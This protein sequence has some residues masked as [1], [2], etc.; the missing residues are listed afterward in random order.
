MTELE[1][2]EGPGNVGQCY[3]VIMDDFVGIY[4]KTGPYRCSWFNKP[5]KTWVRSEV[6]REKI[7]LANN[8][9]TG[10]PGPAQKGGLT[11]IECYFCRRSAVISGALDWTQQE[12]GRW[13]CAAGH[14]LPEQSAKPR[15]V[16][17]KT[18]PAVAQ[19]EEEDMTIA[20]AKALELY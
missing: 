13:L 5:K 17:V 14:K 7:E 9:E 19:Q 16:E 12:D 8:P 3:I 6:T 4:Q 20:R 2:L 11:V 10:L 1:L 15:Q 18:T